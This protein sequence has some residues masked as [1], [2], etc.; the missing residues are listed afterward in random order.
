MK[1]DTSIALSA[2]IVIAS[3]GGCG[4]KPGVESAPKM[5]KKYIHTIKVTGSRD[6]EFWGILSTTSPM[7]HRSLRKLEHQRCPATYTTEPCAYC[8]MAV[9][10][11]FHFPF[12][13]TIERDDMWIA[14]S[15][16]IT[17]YQVFEADCRAGSDRVG[18]TTT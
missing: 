10:D 1:R 17:N 8:S 6:N 11:A 4:Y 9:G 16:T 12:K 14:E 15:S 13:V 3:V 5:P 2:L 7:G 18:T